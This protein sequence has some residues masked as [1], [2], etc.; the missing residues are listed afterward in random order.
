MCLLVSA[1]TLTGTGGVETYDSGVA[2]FKRNIDRLHING[3]G[4]IMRVC[5]FLSRTRS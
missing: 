2:G 3:T 5:Y 4:S 1:D